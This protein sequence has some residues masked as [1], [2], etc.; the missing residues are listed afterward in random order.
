M[1][2]RDE[3]LVKINK[4]KLMVKINKK[5]L[6]VNINNKKLM[7]KNLVVKILMVVIN[8][9]KQSIVVAFMEEI[10]Q[11][12][13][14][15][16]NTEVAVE[17]NNADMNGTD[18]EAVA[19]DTNEEWETFNHEETVRSRKTYSKEKPPYLW[20]MQTFNNGEEF[21]D[22]LLRYV[23]KTNYDVILD[24]WERN[25]LAAIC[26]NEKCDWRI[27]CSFEK[28][29]HKWMVKTYVDK[30]NHGK[31]S[32]ARMLKQG[33][34]GSFEVVCQKAR[35]IALNFVIETQQDQFAMLWDYQKELHRS[36]ERIHAEITTIP[37]HDGKQRFDKFYVCFEPL[38]ETW[39]RV[40]RPIIGLDGAFL[41]WEL[42]REIL[43]AVGKD[44]DN[45][46]YP[47]AWAIVKVEDNELWSWFVDKLKDDLDLGFG[48]GFTIISDMQKRLINAV[49]DVLP[50]AEHRH[51]ARHISANWKKVYG[52]Y[53]HEQYF[54]PIVFSGSEGD[55]RYNMAALEKYDKFSHEDLKKTEPKTWCRAFFSSHAACEDVCNNL[56]ES[57]NR[58]IKDARKMPVIDM[59]EEIRRQ[60]MKRISKRGEKARKCITRF[61][62]HAMEIFEANCKMSKLCS[63]IKSGENLFEVVEGRGS[64]TVNLLYRH[65]ASNQWNITRIPCPHAIHV[66]TENNHDPEDYIDKYFLTTNWIATYMDNTAPV[67]GDR[68]WERT[69][70][71]PIQ[72]PDKRKSRERPKKYARILEAHKSSSQPHK[73]IR[74]GRTN[75]DPW[76]IQNAPK[77]YKAAQSQ[78]TP[79]VSAS[80]STPND[81]SAT[82]PPAVAG[83]SAP[84]RG[85]GHPRGSRNKVHDNGGG[86]G[87]GSQP[88][89][90][91]PPICFMSPWNNQVFD[92]WHPDNP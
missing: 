16:G 62:P 56:S 86:R 65:C 61:A 23:L 15:S 24:K 31:N 92:V 44:A 46:I 7:V 18:G 52:E 8:Q 57:F 36:N 50:N 28:P 34:V 3:I 27:Y 12:E 60:T 73:V 5:K 11:Q 77:R 25:R 45:R 1:E 63:V 90:P 83:P 67:N 76:S 42:K 71:E 13:M 84:K 64:F 4:K 29:K 41:K 9:M 74:H 35:R 20:L 79:T 26:T 82:A 91:R 72:I 66:I 88:P 80:Q 78:S 2:A 55:Y 21:K 51:C 87:R 53:E 37:L 54:W 22:Q 30:H 10:R 47:I 68:L 19:V 32:K 89:S 81:P 59:L 70:K 75:D 6:M 14:R 85:S 58:T 48:N 40:C 17:V 49:S 69:G 39:K 43:A 33:V 38:R